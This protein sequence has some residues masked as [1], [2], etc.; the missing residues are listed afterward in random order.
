LE[1]YREIPYKKFV[2]VPETR[3]VY[4]EQRNLFEEEGG[5]K[6]R[7]SKNSFLGDIFNQF[8]YFDIFVVQSHKES[9]SNAEGKL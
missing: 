1:K 2:E 8:N 5:T 9:N 6:V 7:G 3:S 4:T